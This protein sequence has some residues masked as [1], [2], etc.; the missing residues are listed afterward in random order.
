MEIKRYDELLL[1]AIDYL[2]AEMN[3]NQ[4]EICEECLGMTKEEFESLGNSRDILQFS[5]DIEESY[6]ENLENRIPEILEEAG[7]TVW[8]C[9]WQ[10]R[11]TNEGYHNGKPPIS[12]D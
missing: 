2:E 1:K 12:S 9:T 5:I 6:D 7:Y 11:W 8:G 3:M 4:M 10:A